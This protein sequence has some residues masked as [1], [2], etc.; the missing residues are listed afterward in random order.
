M[1]DCYGNMQ[2]R[3]DE[4]V[5]PILKGQDV[6]GFLIVILIVVMFVLAIGS[7]VSHKK[8]I[9]RIATRNK[10]ARLLKKRGRC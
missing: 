4:G 5:F 8:R 7:V 2:G 3:Q 1:Q 9:G 6:M 10:Q